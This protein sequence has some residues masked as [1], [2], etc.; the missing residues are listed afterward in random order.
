MKIRSRKVK[1]QPMK[2]LEHSALKI[3]SEEW[4]AR[5]MPGVSGGVDAARGGMPTA[6]IGYLTRLSMTSSWWAE[7]KPVPEAFRVVYDAKRHR[8]GCD[9]PVCA[10]GRSLGRKIPSHRRRLT[11]GF[12]SGDP[13][14]CGSPRR[15][16]AHLHRAVRVRGHF[17]NDD[18]A[19]KLPYPVLDAP[20]R[21][22]HAPRVDRGRDPIRRDVRQPL[23]RTGFAQKI[24]DSPR[25]SAGTRKLSRQR[26]I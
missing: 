7:R 18:A 26:R 17:R 9:C 10:R 1:R 15:A 5:A 22:A 19:T 21:D 8:G 13:I 3:N 4:T 14:F 12:A 16:P 24:P 20:T 23:P 2:H 11:V 25:R 6:R